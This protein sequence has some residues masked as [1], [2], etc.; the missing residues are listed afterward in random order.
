MKKL[1]LAVLFLGGM[2]AQANEVTNLAQL[3]KGTRYNQPQSITFIERGI[4]YVVYVNGEFDFI[5][6]QPQQSFGRR[7]SV[8]SAPGIT[9]GV[10]YATPRNFVR[11]GFNGEIVRVGRTQIRYNR[12][13]DVNQIGSVRLRY[14]K[15]LLVR[16]GDLHINYDRRG[17]IRNVDGYVHHNHTN[18]GICGING[19]TTNHF[20]YRDS[21]SNRKYYNPKKDKKYFKKGK[22][23]KNKNRYDD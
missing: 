3:E 10:T 23:K 12:Y 22:Y 6:N 2:T 11:Y 4:E 14:H 15:G 17:F 19:C 9:Y 13:G 1:L 20:D 7:G 8:A 18:C 21:H 16:A 5:L